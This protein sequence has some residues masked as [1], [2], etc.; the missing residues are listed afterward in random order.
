[1]NEISYCKRFFSKELI[2]LNYSDIVDYFKIEREESDK[3][4]FKSYET[5]IEEKFKE[6][7]NGVIR[8]ICALLNSEGGIVIWGAP[9]GKSID[10][11]KEKIFMGEL[12][13]CEKLIENDF[14]INRITDLI[15]PSPKGV[16]F[17][18]LENKNK[19]IYVIEVDKSIYSPH[20]FRNIYYMRIDGQT[21]PA[22]HHYIEAL[23]KKITYPR[24]EGYLKFENIVNDNFGNYLLY[25]SL[26]IFNKS[27]LQNEYEINYRLITTVG[28]FS[29][30]NLQMNN[31]IFHLEGHELRILNAKSVL[32]YN[33]P[34]YYQCI[35][36]IPP[37]QLEKYKNEIEFHLYFGGK[38]S[39]LMISKYKLLLW[40]YEPRNLY[41]SLTYFEENIYSYEH[42]DN[43]ELSEEEKLK[44]LL[45]R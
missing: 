15:T 29:G 41:K 12:S 23:F 26:F 9:K 25:V 43:M 20:Q 22:P 2:D 35:I 17:Q 14:F 18:K 32:Y 10:G 31:D 30:Y 19:F 6:K 42:T 3:I 40:N 45:G 13:P 24:L 11:K 34:F 33:E 8:T 4:E 37:K 44:I 36:V 28:T 1:M 27:K 16:R 5:E 38:N 21:R 39:P 7:E